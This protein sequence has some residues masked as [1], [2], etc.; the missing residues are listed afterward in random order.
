MRVYLIAS[1]PYG[2]LHH[3]FQ[4]L[5]DGF[6]ALSL[7]VTYLE[8][9]YGWR[10][11][12]WGG[13][14]GLGR[15][16]RFAFRHHLRVL[17]RRGRNV[18]AQASESPSGDMAPAFEVVQLPLVI[19][20]NRLNSAVVEGVNARVFRSV[21][22][23]KMLSREEEETV[24]IVD[25]PLWGAVL[26]RGD[27]TRIYYDCIDDVAL[28]AGHASLD[29]FLEYERRLVRCSD[30]VFV[31]AASLEDRLRSIDPSK[32]VFRLPNGVDY[33]WFQREASRRTKPDDIR[34]IPRPVVGYVG[35]IADWMDYALVNDVAMRRPGVSFVFVGPTDHP[36]RAAQLERSENVYW[37]GKKPYHEVPVYVAAFDVCWIPFLGGRIV[38]HT[39]P[40]KLYEY[41]ALGKPVVTTAMSEVAQFQG[42]HLV[43]TGEGAGVVGA[44]LDQAL[45][46]GD[47]NRRFRRL[48]IAREHSWSGIVHRMHAIITGRHE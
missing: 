46:D 18:P 8:Q 17:L 38:E 45:N 26:E 47:D 35:S 31:T 21:L 12:L 20:T 44:A 43:Y 13:R 25:N 22:Q 33:E 37:L 24:A 30:A 14:E 9:T 27:F 40:I 11:Y 2:Y 42:E 3:R 23:E 7:D 4:K 34:T 36:G 32:P 16:V 10:A 6:R 39:N 48:A 41:F 15:E 1:T 28:Y 5:A 19:P 29:R